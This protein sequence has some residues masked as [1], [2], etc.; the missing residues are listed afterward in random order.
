MSTSNDR[1]LV[2]AAG[3]TADESLAREQLEHPDPKTRASAIRAL[4]RM[5]RL[6][7]SDVSAAIDDG[8][9]LVR[10]AAVECAVP[11]DDV[12]VDRLL[13]DP[14]LFVAEMTAWCLGER[15]CTDESI[16]SLVRAAREHHEP[17]VRE[18]SVAA[19]GSLGDERGLEAIL[20]AC[21]DKPAVRRRAVLALAPFDDPRVDE[22]LRV[23]L[24]DR[25]WQVRQNAEILTSPRGAGD[26]A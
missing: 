9:E 21:A 5:D 14:D 17:V 18:A 10:L 3:F 13:D 4:A 8:S 25:D 23:A 16:T 1:F 26:Q 22:A 11:F 19:L 6:T 2:I 7:S 15:V 24:E 12:A 20:A